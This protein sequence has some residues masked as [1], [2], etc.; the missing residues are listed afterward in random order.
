MNANGDP[1]DR[2]RRQRAQRLS[3]RGAAYL[4]QGKAHSALSLLQRAHELVPD[5]VP[6]AINLGGA[7][8]LR[9]QFSRAIP[10]LERA[11][12]QE[13]DN[14]MVW[15]NLGAAYLGNPV[16][17]TD[18]QQRKAIAAFERAAEI[19][20][21]APNVHYNL[22]LIHRDR[23]EI[24]QAVYRFQRAIQANPHDADARRALER[25]QDQQQE[26][27]DAGEPGSGG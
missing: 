17:A 25:L 3:N 8:I 4:R 1:A 15:I 12:E 9:K 24:E 26:S 16:L 27:A 14:E 6:T 18:E 19:N 2:E 13:P 21:V 20:P 23:D 10:I 11:G 7:Y 22:A 5:D